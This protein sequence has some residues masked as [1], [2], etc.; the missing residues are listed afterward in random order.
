MTG[1][2]ANRDGL[3][4]LA[5]D[6]RSLAR[7]VLRASPR[8][9]VRFPAELKWYLGSLRQYRSMLLESGV[10]EPL[11][12]YPVLFQRDEVDF[13]AHYTF[14]AAWATKRILSERPDRH[15]DIASDIRFVTQLSAAVPVLYLEYRPMELNL[16]GLNIEQ[17]SV[18]SMRF[19]SGSLASL[20]CL[21][22]IEHIGLGRYGDE[23]DVRGPEKACRELARV[24][25]P[26]GTLYLSVP[27]GRKVTLF[28][29][30][31]IFDPVQVPELLPNLE[32]QEFS[33]VDTKGRYIENAS[34]ADFRDEEYACG[35]YRFG[36][37]RSG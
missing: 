13:D 19:E 29:A 4:R 2:I 12:H 34:P 23:L 28:N 18:L 9:W 25:A 6:V 30:H 27:V 20:S 26:G 33:V 1:E 21:H 35:L 31:R 17:G 16:P 22:V 5:S 24:L 15:V 36:K 11:D 10:P 7:Q 3:R 37:P 8:H 32:L 14:Q